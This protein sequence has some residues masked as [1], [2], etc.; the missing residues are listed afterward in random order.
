M[1]NNL[2]K[3]YSTT[4]FYITMQKSIWIVNFKLLKSLHPFLGPQEEVQVQHSDI[5]ANS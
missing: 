3:I 2:L 1:F 5:Q 4:I